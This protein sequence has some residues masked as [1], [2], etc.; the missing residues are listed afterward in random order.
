MSRSIILGKLCFKLF[1]YFVNVWTLKMNMNKTITQSRRTHE[2][3]A[4][5]INY[6]IL[7]LLQNNV[8]IKLNAVSR[9][10]T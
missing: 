2:K 9:S 1:F 10:F 8:F 6:F 7:A 4:K 3:T 5:T